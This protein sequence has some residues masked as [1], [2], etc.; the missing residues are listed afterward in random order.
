MHKIHSVGEIR[1]FADIC[2]GGFFLDAGE[3]KEG[4]GCEDHTIDGAEAP[5]D[6]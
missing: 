5:S 4:S 1:A 2:R 6:L 3:E